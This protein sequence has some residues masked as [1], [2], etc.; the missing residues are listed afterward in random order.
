MTRRFQGLNQTAQPAPG[1]LPDGL[2]LVR[3]EKA[4]YR[5]H[6]H[7]PFYILRLS[8]LEPQEFAGQI[9]SGPALLRRQGT[10]ET[11][12]VPAR[13]RLDAELLGRD[14]VDEKAMLERFAQD[15]RVRILRP[16]GSLQVKFTRPIPPAASDFVAY[17]DAFGKLDGEGCLL[18][19]KTASSRYPE[20]PVGLLALDPQLVCYSWIT[21]ISDVAQVVFVRKPLVE[22]QYMRDYH[23][24]R[25]KTRLWP[26]DRRHDPANRGL[27]VHA[28][29]RHPLSPEPLHQLSLRRLLP[30]TAGTGGEKRNTAPGRRPW[31]A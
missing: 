17:I 22:V 4:Q 30:G 1:E 21:G 8:V 26:P 20:E 2:Y 11:G 19:W 10:L 6:P 28:P 5:W 3:V 29:Q 12:L 14:E 16:R 15:D 24:L 9:L 18:E 31:L 25:T 27:S 23:H 13:L 7:K